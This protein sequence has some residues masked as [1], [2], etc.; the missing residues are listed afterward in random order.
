MIT[1]ILMLLAPVAVFLGSLPLSSKLRSGFCLAYRT[2]GGL[3]VFAGSATSYYFANYGG[4][5]G[6]IAAFFFQS[7]VISAYLLF[8]AVLITAN[9]LMKNKIYSNSS[10]RRMRHGDQR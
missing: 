8:S 7:A 5:Q 9:W 2:G 10:Y 4:D 3:I 1:G 6:G